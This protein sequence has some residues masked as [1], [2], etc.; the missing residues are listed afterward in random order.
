MQKILILLAGLALA[1]ALAADAAPDQAAQPSGVIPS[2]A[3]DSPEARDYA[4]GVAAYYRIPLRQVSALQAQG[5]PVEELPV[6]C[7]V[8]ARARVRPSLVARLRLGGASWMSISRRFGFGPEAFYW[9]PAAAALEGPLCRHLRPF[10]R[11]APPRLAAPGPQ[12]PGRGQLR[13]PPLRGGALALQPGR[14]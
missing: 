12:R 14:G 2:L 10:P 4:A 11:H 7:A 3:P 1:G 13:Q 8:A 6:V 5:V 9:A